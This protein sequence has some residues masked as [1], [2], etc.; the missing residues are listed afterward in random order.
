MKVRASAWVEDGTLGI[1]HS[2]RVTKIASIDGR[3]PAAIERRYPNLVRVLFEKPGDDREP[4]PSSFGA[5]PEY[6]WDGQP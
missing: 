5:L 2:G 1:D 6:V 3:R 4:L